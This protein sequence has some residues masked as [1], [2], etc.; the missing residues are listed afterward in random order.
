[1]VTDLIS[2]LE[3]QNIR[4]INPQP[5]A[6][7]QW[8]DMIDD[9]TKNTLFPLTNSWW[10]ASNIA[11]KKVQMLTYIGGINTYEP[12]CRAALKELKGFDVEYSKESSV[13]NGEAGRSAVETSS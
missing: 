8:V 5:V 6:Q 2:S 4:S 9:M 13:G 3:K 7:Q 11:G 12:L 10:N 1:M